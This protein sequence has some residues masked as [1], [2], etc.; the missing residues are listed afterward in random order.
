[1]KREI[2]FRGKRSTDRKWIYGL[3]REVDRSLRQ[4]TIDYEDED[5]HNSDPVDSDTICEY[6]GLKDKNRKK[7]F[8]GDCLK[9]TGCTGEVY[10]QEVRWTTAFN[11]AGFRLVDSDGYWD[12]FDDYEGRI[13]VIGNIYDN[14][15]L[16]NK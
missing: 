7:I 15:Q 6:I 3:P 4:W 2:L 8:E 16:L 1:M 9:T 14:P 13:E 5:G 10:I 11:I 12:D